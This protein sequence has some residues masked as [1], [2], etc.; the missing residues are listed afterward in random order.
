MKMRKKQNPLNSKLKAVVADY[1]TS[2]IELIS[3]VTKDNINQTIS[4]IKANIKVLEDEVNKSF[5]YKKRDYSRD[6]KYYD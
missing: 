2:V 1:A 3:S 6:I 4:L 5:S